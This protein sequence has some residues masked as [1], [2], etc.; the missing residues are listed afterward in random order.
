[1]FDSPLDFFSLLIAIV[2]LMVA[3]KALKQAAGLRARLDSIET[4]SAAAA[5][6]MPPG[7]STGT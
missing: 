7:Q 6:P 5:R 1:M 3:R 4:T 2:A